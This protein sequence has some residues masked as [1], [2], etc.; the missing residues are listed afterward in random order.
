M[1]LIQCLCLLDGVDASFLYRYD[2]QNHKTFCTIR[3]PKGGIHAGELAYEQQKGGGSKVS[4][5]F[6]IDGIFIP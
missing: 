4:A 1:L 5:G 2:L 6:S 3:T